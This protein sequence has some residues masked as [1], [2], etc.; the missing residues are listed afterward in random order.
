MQITCFASSHRVE[1]WLDGYNVRTAKLIFTATNHLRHQALKYKADECQG[2]RPRPRA[3][4]HYQVQVFYSIIHIGTFICQEDWSRL[5]RSF[6]A[7]MQARR[8]GHKGRTGCRCCCC[9]FKNAGGPSAGK[10][11]HFSFMGPLNAH[12]TANLN[13]KKKK[14]TR[15]SRILTKKKYICLFTTNREKM[16]GQQ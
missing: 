3:I 14:H 1:V 13:K 12:T 5:S 4:Q 8:M 15:F 9:A 6:F 11:A 7:R 10:N 2:E 16:R